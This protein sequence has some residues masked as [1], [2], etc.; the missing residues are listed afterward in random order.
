MRT[1]KIGTRTKD[2]KI[3]SGDLL[4]EYVQKNG[5]P[6]VPS[7]Y[8]DNPS[9]GGWVGYVRRTYRN[10]K[11]SQKHIDLLEGLQGWQWRMR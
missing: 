8:P 3:K 10:G 6:N 5:N 1:C 4:Q 7:E 9:L 2:P 11:I